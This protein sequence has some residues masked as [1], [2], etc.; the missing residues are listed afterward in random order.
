V[1]QH[2]IIE[3]GQWPMKRHQQYATG[4]L[5]GRSGANGLVPLSW[6]ISK[7]IE[8]Q[9]IRHGRK[10][11]CIAAGGLIASLLALNACAYLIG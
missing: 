3:Q 8:R 11:N 6:A 9:N 2:F 5:G 7:L 10:L 1:E 4:Q